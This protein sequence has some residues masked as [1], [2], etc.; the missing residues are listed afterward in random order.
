SSMKPIRTA[1]L[2]Y[3]YGALVLLFMLAKPCFIY[4]QSEAVRGEVP[5]ADMARILWHG[6][7]LDLA[8]AGYATA[9]LWLLLGLSLWFRL[10]GLRIV[11]RAYAAIVAAVVSIT[12]VADT[13]LYG[14]WGIKLDGTI[15]NY[16]SQPGGALASVSMNYAMWAVLATVLAAAVI[17][18]LLRSI[19]PPT[20][21]PCRHRGW[22]TALWT[23]M[24]GLLFLG[25]RGGVGKS[26]A[27][28]GMAYWT[29][30][31]FLNHAAVNPLF[32]VMASLQKTRNFQDECDFFSEDERAR[33]FATLHY[34]TES[35]R[36]DTLLRTPRP[37]VLLVLMEGC[38]ATFV[39]AVDSASNP[40]ITPCLNRLAAEGIVFTECY[41]NSFRTDRGTLCALSGFPAFPD[42]SVMKLPGKY[43]HLPSIAASLRQAGYATEFL[44]GGDIN[45]TKMKGYL[46][47]T[48][49]ETI[50]GD[51]HFPLEVRRTHAWGVTDGIVLDTLFNHVIAPAPD[52]KPRFTVCLT[53]ASHE[54]WA[55]PFEKFPD[56][57]RTNAMAYLDD[58]IGRFVQRL[59]STPEWSNTLLVLLPDHG[60]GYPEDITPP[61]PRRYHIPLIWA[62]G[63]LAKPMRYE[64]VCNQS[65]LAAT[66]LAQLRLPHADFLFSRNVLAP[67]YT[68]PT[69]FHSWSEGIACVDSA[70]CTVWHLASERVIWDKPEPSASR[71]NA[72]KAYWQTAYDEVGRL[73]KE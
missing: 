62:G 35:L 10:R 65:D 13:C 24:G 20:L 60:I 16:L 43:G 68:R 17:Y 18:A 67:S 31:P 55:V 23:L 53:L 19:M 12:L 33:L 73:N 6:R 29:D 9:P 70:G 44:Y 4:V 15:W 49:F 21:P 50:L 69:A 27:N 41:A 54:P 58:C 36:P 7:P 38:G 25:I 71:L 30:R 57:K 32:S 42:V 52:G 11:Y 40:S 8:T 39:H 14:F 28:V 51:T 34:N 47:A 37:N 48:G 1:T 61:D 26:T 63:A 64:K 22:G 59:R 2:A 3:F 56:N 5:A 66:L 45:F 72:A 46:S